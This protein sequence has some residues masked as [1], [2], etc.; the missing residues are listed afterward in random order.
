MRNRG[1]LLFF[2]FIVIKQTFSIHI[3]KFGGQCIRSAFRF[4][5]TTPFWRVYQNIFSRLVQLL[6]ATRRGV[7]PAEERRLCEIVNPRRMKPRIRTRPSSTRLLTGWQRRRSSSRQSAGINRVSGEDKGYRRELRLV[8]TSSRERHFLHQ[9][10][11]WHSSTDATR[12]LSLSLYLSLRTHLC[13]RSR[14]L[15]GLRSHPLEVIFR[16]WILKL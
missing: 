4:Y 1:I 5:Q 11:D 2:L 6:D 12:S 10:T 7:Y 16:Q 3:R 8:N 9:L 14:T 13:T 15:F